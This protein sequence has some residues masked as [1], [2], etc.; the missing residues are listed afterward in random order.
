MR[1]NK[2]MA[3]VHLMREYLKYVIAELEAEIEH[4]QSIYMDED[5]SD[6]LIYEQMCNEERQAAYIWYGRAIERGVRVSIAN[7]AFERFG[8]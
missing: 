4:I 5:M 1:T 3:R 7:K 6:D 2:S 8:I